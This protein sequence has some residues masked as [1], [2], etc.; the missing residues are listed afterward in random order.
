MKLDNVTPV[1]SGNNS[2]SVSCYH[3]A[4]E[5]SGRQIRLDITWKQERNDTYYDIW[6]TK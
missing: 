1:S 2:G 3:K 6:K 4:I 5:N